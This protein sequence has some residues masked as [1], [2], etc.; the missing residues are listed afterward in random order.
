MA[1]NKTFLLFADIAVTDGGVSTR[2]DPDA[3]I[4]VPR[5]HA[6]L[7]SALPILIDEDAGSL[8]VTDL[9]VSDG[10]VSPRRDCHSHT[11]VP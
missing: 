9:A 5:D 6:R 4:R 3:S 10:G 1:M 2:R 11:C 7:D 8:P